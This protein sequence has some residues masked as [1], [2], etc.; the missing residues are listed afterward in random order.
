[1]QPNC[2]EGDDVLLPDLGMVHVVKLYQS[3][4]AVCEDTNGVR[5]LVAADSLAVAEPCLFS[6]LP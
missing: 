6:H 4:A 3:G 5:W 1:M 2:N